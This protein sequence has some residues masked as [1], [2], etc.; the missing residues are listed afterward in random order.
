MSVQTVSPLS[1]RRFL[2]RAGLGSI[3]LASLPAIADALAVP[4]GAEGNQTHFHFDC[5]VLGPTTPAGV[6]HFLAMAGCGKFGDAE[7]EGHGSFLHFDAASAVPRHIIGSGTWKANRLTSFQPF[8]DPYGVFQ[9]GIAHLDINLVRLVPS[10]AVVPATLRI[11]C[12]VGPA[13]PASIT[14]LPENIVV[15]VDGL[16]FDSPVAGLTVFTTAVEERD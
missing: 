11:V 10:F 4:V 6:K 8:G 13:G 7:V 16:T 12:N 14:G 15:H 2:K 1:R 5:Q 3:A 9:A